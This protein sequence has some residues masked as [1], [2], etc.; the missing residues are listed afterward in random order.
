[1]VKNKINNKQFDFIS[2]GEPLLRLS[3]AGFG[4]LKT[5]SSLDMYLA[6]A[7]YNVAS[8]MARLGRKS[9]FLTKLPDNPLGRLAADTMNKY[10]ID[11][12]YI[13]FVKDSKIGI[14]FVEFSVSP[15]AP[16][17]VFDRKN[18]AAST[19]TPSDFDLADLLAT[20][21]VA[22]TDG[23]FSGL[24]RTCGDTALKY[25]RLARQNKCITCFD[26]NYRQHLWTPSRARTVWSI[27][28]NHVDV[29]VTNRDVSEQVFGYKGTDEQ[30]M[31]HYVDRFG[32]KIVCMTYR[33]MAGLQKGA[34]NSVCLSNGK[35]Y[36]GT[37]KEF[38][39][40]DRYGTGDAW[41]SGFIYGYTQKNDVN[42]AL[43][44]GNASCA[45]AHTV[46]GDVADFSGEDILSA[47][48]DNPDLRVKR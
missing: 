44:F 18:S 2:I 1:M 25:F 27:L 48:K 39:I 35:L 29:L 24:S 23:I 7:Q 34:W 31:K 13:K 37:R 21:S 45:L 30:I 22:Y 38:D 42:F 40:I 47:M 15:R 26:M 16:V 17:S 3:P 41:F 33:E 10:G 46:M 28:L 36:T 8:N 43:N 6:G 14:T 32:T 9:V 12:S 19:I 11:T 5:A 4:Q 20:T